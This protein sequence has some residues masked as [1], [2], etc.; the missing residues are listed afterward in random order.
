MFLSKER[1]IDGKPRIMQVRGLFRTVKN[2]ILDVRLR[3]KYA[4]ATACFSDNV[5]L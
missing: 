2:Y 4:F 1:L 5:T 3:S